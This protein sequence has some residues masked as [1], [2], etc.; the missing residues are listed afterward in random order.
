MSN[1]VTTPYPLFSDIDGTPLDAGFY[2][3]VKVE[4]MQSNFQFQFI[5]MKLKLN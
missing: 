2:I 5:G 4:K 3:L 1:K